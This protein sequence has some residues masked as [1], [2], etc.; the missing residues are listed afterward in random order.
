MIKVIIV[1][2]DPMVAEFNKRYLEKI[3]GYQLINSFKTVEDALPFIDAHDID[4][5]LLDI[6]MPGKNG[7]ELLSKIRMANKNVDVMIISAA[8]DKESIKKGLRLGA[9]DYLIKPFE[10]ERFQK[11]LASYREENSFMN[12]KHDFH[13][14][15]LDDNLFRKD[16]HGSGETI[17]LPKGLTKPTLKKVIKT[18]E[19]SERASFTT[20][21]LAEETG[22]SR[23]SVRK[24][25]A[26]LLELGMVEETMNYHTV[27]R[28][29]VIYHVTSI[30]FAICEK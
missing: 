21:M 28:P 6:Y 14:K 11:A 23:V 13:Q 9:V 17:E 22:I 29:S 7:W 30:D 3:D 16:H 20:D 24:Y 26:Y 27:G 2:D 12:Q 1:E 4:L 19:A 15:D 25:L 8:R 18:I 5:I 10:F